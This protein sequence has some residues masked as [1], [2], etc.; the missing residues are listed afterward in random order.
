MNVQTST[1]GSVSPDGN[2]KESESENAGGA[3]KESSQEETAPKEGA[4]AEDTAQGEEEHLAEGRAPRLARSPVTPSRKEVEEHSATH[5]PYRSWCPHCVKGRGNNQP[6][7]KSAEKD[8]DDSVPV[9][10][11]DYGFMTKKGTDDQMGPML[12]LKESRH[13]LVKSMVVP[14]KGPSQEWVPRRCHSWI[15]DIGYPK[16]VLKNDNEPAI[17]ALAKEIRNGSRGIADTVRME[18]IIPENSEVGE[19]QSN[20]RTERAVGSMEG[21]IRTLKS[22]LEERIGIKLEPTDN[23]LKWLVEHASYLY[24]NFHVGLDGRT[25]VE[26]WKGRRTPR[27]ICDLGEAVM[28]LPLKGARPGKF[29]DKFQDGVMLGVI[30]RTG[31]IIIGTP[32][33]AVRTRT[34]KRMPEDKRWKADLVKGVVGLP[35]AP[36]GDDKEKPIAIQIKVEVPQLDVPSEPDPLKQVKREFLKK[37]DYSVHGYT[38]G[39]QGCVALQR[40]RKA[41]NHSEACRTRMERILAGT[42]TGKARLKRT[43]EKIQEA[44]AESVAKRAKTDS[45]TDQRERAREAPQQ[46]SEA[47]SSSSGAPVATP[48]GPI[49][50]QAAP[51]DVDMDPGDGVVQESEAKRQRILQLSSETVSDG[52]SGNK[53]RPE[54]AEVYSPP[55]IAAQ[56][57]SQG[58]KGGWSLD[59]T[60]VNDAGERWDFNDPKKR[61]QAK[62]LVQERKPRMLIGS[63]M[64]TAFSA[65]QTLNRGA[66]SQGEWNEWVRQAIIH[67]DFCCELYEIQVRRGDYFL[68]EHPATA[69]SWSLPRI[70]RV[71]SMKGVQVVIGDM[72]QFGMV[73][74]D[75]D[76]PGLIKKPTKFMT[77]CGKV[78]EALAVRCEGGHRH[79]SLIGGRAKAAQEYP[80]ELCKTVIKALRAQL[81]QDRQTVIAHMHNGKTL[82]DKLSEARSASKSQN[83]DQIA[84]TVNTLLH[85]DL[86]GSLSENGYW[87]DAKGGWLDPGLVVRAREEEMGYVRKHSVYTKV[88]TAQCWRDTGKAPVK[89]G[90][91]DTNKGTDGDPN[92][93]SRWV[94]KEYNT[95][96]RLDLYAP[97]PPLEGVKLVASDVASRKGRVMVTVDVRRAYFYAKARRKIYVELPDEDKGPGDVDMCGMLNVSLYG[98]RDAAQNWEEELGGFLLSLGFIKGRG[99]TCMYRH[100]AR[101]IKAAVHGDDLAASCERKQAEWL[102]KVMKDRYEV[103]TQMMGADRDLDKE[104]KLLNRSFR[105]SKQGIWIEA[106]PRHVK[107]ILKDLELDNCQTVSTPGSDSDKSGKD[108]E[109]YLEPAKATAF[110]AVAARLNYLCQDRPDIRF[111]TMNACRAMAAPRK[112]DL[113]CLKRIGRFLKLRPRVACLYGWQSDGDRVD[114]Y[115]DSDWAGCKESRKSTTGGCVMK[116]MHCLKAWCKRQTVIALSSAEAELYAALKGAMEGLGIKALRADLGG[117]TEL[118]LHLDSSAALSLVHKAGLGKAKHVELQHLWLQDAVKQ[119][120]LTALKVNTEWNPGDLMTKNLSEEKILRMTK[121]MGYHYI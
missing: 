71:A 27:Q 117:E 55:R 23:I 75:K 53:L 99:S 86:L 1:S 15:A 77:N 2:V 8:K 85:E 24:N 104:L 54:V 36:E 63:P 48:A 96:V 20:G 67:L 37:G 39:C 110:R 26:R 89:T 46:S 81:A 31:E 33:G 50:Q 28:Y 62:K 78:A 18:A 11:M 16:V 35:W 4:L 21:L 92:V 38:D 22:A 112:C 94:G 32:L 105:W 91:V 103:R 101:Q 25:P 107:E 3:D 87:D 51:E 64:C 121:L 120:R 9:I 82:Y 83:K 52:V 58:M 98:T 17:E 42:A 113:A 56:G 119:K 90:W 79:I 109:E 95:G 111:A 80:K 84:A 100:P 44:L 68:H 73:Q 7:R 57:E 13:G 70:R 74:V 5:M 115:S 43:E 12:V 93:R 47:S 97:T 19:S 6:H 76:G 60:T 34:I 49:P 29:D 59:L 30:Q 72:C 114:V 40:G 10:G 65:L 118:R 88:P 69:T 66:Y 116:G 45:G 102:T 106:D 14:A 61:A 41:E 108:Q